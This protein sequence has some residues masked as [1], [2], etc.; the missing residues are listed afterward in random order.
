VLIIFKFQFPPHSKHIFT[1][2]LKI[3]RLMPYRV[4]S[5]VTLNT[6]D[7]VQTEWVHWTK[8]AWMEAG[9]I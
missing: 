8:S 1:F 6:A 7:C 3:G 4:A 5:V 2:I 9:G